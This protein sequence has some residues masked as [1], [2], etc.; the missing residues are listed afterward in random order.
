[1]PARILELGSYIVPGYAGMILAEQGFEVEKW[2]GDHRDPIEELREGDKLWQWINHG[3]RIEH[4][5][6]STVELL[7]AGERPDAIIDNLRAS[8]W[9]SWG[10][11]PAQLAD[12][13]AIPWVSCRADL[14]DHDGRSFDVIAQ[15]RAWG[16]RTP[17]VPFYIGDTAV[18]LT[19]A[20]KVLALLAA[21]RGGHHVIHQ[22]A[23][24]A[25]LVEGEDVVP[26]I[27]RWGGPTPW[28]LPLT[29]YRNVR[30]AFVDFRGE[31]VREPNRDRTWRLAH[32]H[33]DGNGRYIV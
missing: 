10:V 9:A 2:L 26:V 6:A 14:D 24:L 31:R 22:A 11:D 21:R 18:G 19:V 29:Y 1:M 3:K 28:D 17:W 5:H 8:T 32:L 13:W 7:P 30:G 27:R 23:A 16:D 25:K 20:F 15:A 4:R 12:R 33:H